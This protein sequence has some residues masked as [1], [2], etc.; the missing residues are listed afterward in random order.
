[1]DFGG[2]LLKAV[3]ERLVTFKRRILGEQFSRFFARRF[4][5]F[6]ISERSHSQIGQAGLARADKVAWSA[7][8]EVFLGQLKSVAA[9]QKRF[10]ALISFHRVCS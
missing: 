3:A 1:M 2:E 9:L 5:E 7:Q 10:Q 4:D 6:R 8:S